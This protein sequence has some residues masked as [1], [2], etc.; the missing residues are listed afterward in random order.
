MI[1]RCKECGGPIKSPDP[2]S[3]KEGE[4]LIP[5]N[6]GDICWHKIIAIREDEKRFHMLYEFGTDPEGIINGFSTYS[7]SKNYFWK[8]YTIK[9]NDQ[10]KTSP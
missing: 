3:P 2:E 5:T 9:N 6:P 7:L 4:I 10:K 1:K 8:T